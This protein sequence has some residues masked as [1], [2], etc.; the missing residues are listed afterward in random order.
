MDIWLVILKEEIH[1]KQIVVLSSSMKLGPGG[2]ECMEQLT[3]CFYNHYI[4]E[5]SNYKQPHSTFVS[6][7]CYNFLYMCHIDT[8][9]GF[10]GGQTPLWV[11][12]LTRQ[13]DPFLGHFDTDSVSQDQLCLK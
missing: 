4:T 1:A 5:S 10:P 13:F 11:R 12:L 9:S 8:D 7:H 3:R 6:V 2:L